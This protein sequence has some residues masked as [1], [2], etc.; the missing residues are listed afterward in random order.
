[1]L[2]STCP[3]P[4]L[5]RSSFGWSYARL[6]R[7]ALP[8]ARVT[9]AGLVGEYGDS[10]PH[11]AAPA[12]ISWPVTFSFGWASFHFFTVALPQVIS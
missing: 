10:N 5:A 11:D 8:R 9:D 12:G 1:M 6:L 2:F 3:L 7:C 4:A